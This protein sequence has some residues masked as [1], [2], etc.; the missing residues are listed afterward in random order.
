MGL[1]SV[2]QVRTERMPHRE[3]EDMAIGPLG[4]GWET[5]QEPILTAEA[6]AAM[7]P[8][9]CREVTFASNLT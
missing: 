6:D 1:R 3:T 5:G 2:A 4:F 7:N 9:W 8:N